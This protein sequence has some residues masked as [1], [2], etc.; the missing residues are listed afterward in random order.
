MPIEVFKGLRKASGLD[1]FQNGK[2]GDVMNLFF[3]VNKYYFG[4]TFMVME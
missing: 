3:F 2:F 1:R 4:V